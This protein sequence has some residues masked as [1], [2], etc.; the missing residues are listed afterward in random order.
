MAATIGTGAILCAVI[1]AWPYLT[2]Q[3]A[4]MRPFVPI[5]ATAA[6]LTEALTAFLLWTQYRASGR[7]YFAALAGAYAFTSMAAAF[8]L[9]VYPGI[10]AIESSRSAGRESAI[11]IWLLWRGGF[12]LLV[13]LALCARTHPAIEDRERRGSYAI[14]TIGG[15]I[16]VS[17][18]LCRSAIAGRNLLPSLVVSAGAYRHLSASP[19]ALSVAGICLAALALHLWAT[20]L[21]TLMDLW[22][23]VALFAG[24]ADVVLTLG[25]G[26]RYSLG[27]YAA[28]IA[29]T[30]SASAVLGMLMYETSRTYSKLAD[31]HC[32]L[33]ELSVRDGLTGVFNRAYFDERYPR[34]LTQAAAAARPL[35]VLLV[36]VDHFKAYNDALGHLAGDECLRRIAQT[37]DRALMHP[38]D[39]VAR[40]GGEEFVVV[41]PAC[42]ALASLTTAE[43]LRRS[44]ADIAMAG[45]ASPYV[46]VSIGHASCESHNAPQPAT[47]LAH[48]DE[49]LY[50]AKTL[51]R[52]RVENATAGKP[53][54]SSVAEQA[55]CAH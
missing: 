25:A 13:T 23:A 11:W 41:L 22:L 54:A 37:L 31:A 24:F 17:A 33:K 50:R 20:R 30:V 1:V 45:P 47:L 49:A 8:H 34:E 52:N 28:R 53:K 42:D 18:V 10:F 9:A 2:V 36:D 32:A 12:A 48:A 4:V 19:A 35:A 55:E 7:I 39:F 14:L 5:Y 15:A 16:A 38:G 3:G 29:S 21:R 46:T 26:A 40:Y 6:S 44:V 43:R 51:G 27:W